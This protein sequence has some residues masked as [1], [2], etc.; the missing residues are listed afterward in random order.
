MSPEHG[1]NIFFIPPQ[2]AYFQNADSHWLLRAEYGFFLHIVSIL[3]SNFKSVSI[4][5]NPRNG[6][7]PSKMK[8][9]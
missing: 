2:I 9:D 5:L 8:K 3:T 6:V 4:T 1:K 7:G